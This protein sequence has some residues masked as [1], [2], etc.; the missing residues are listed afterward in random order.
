ME[1]D[2]SV[3]KEKANR[4][5]RRIWLIFAILLSANY[6]S[7]LANGLSTSTYYIIFL[8]LCWI[9]IISG[10]ILLRAKGFAT[11]AYKYN[12]V[13]GYGVFY[14]FVISTTES[15]IAFTYILPVTSLLVLYK[16]K[17]FMVTCGIVNSLIIAGSSVYRY[18]N[19]FNTA[20]DLKNYQLE[21]ACIILCYVCYVMSIKHLNESDGAMTDSIKA[22]LKRVVTTVEKVKQASNSIM[23]GVTVVR[24][25]ASENSHGAN[26]VVDS[27]DRLR[28]NNERLH[29]S[30]DSSSQMTTDINLQ[31]NNVVGMIDK[32]VALTAESGKHARV[33]SSD[34]DSLID[35][36]KTMASLSEEIG[37]ILRTFKDEFAM[38]KNETGTIENI[39]GQTNLLALNASIE[40]AR[41]GEA[42]KGFAVVADQIRS[43][44]TD[45]RA[46]SGT[47]KEALTR[48]D[49]TS[50]KM[51]DSIEQTL[52]LIQ[53][54]LDK[55]MLAA[56]NIAKI[57]EDA[58]ELD[59]NIRMI[60]TAIKDVESSNIHL[61]DNLTE[62]TG[63]VADMTESVTD[64]NEI[65]KRMLS[66]YDETASN[67]NSIEK[68][69]E[70]L[71]CELGIGGFMGVEDLL[72][73][74]KL[75]VE[76]G[77]DN[78][79]YGELISHDD[80]VMTIRLNNDGIIADNTEC[81]VQVTVGNV[82]YC[83]DKVRVKGI[84]A[85]RTYS[86]FIE[87]R[88]K[89]NNRRKYPRVDIDNSCTVTIK[90]TGRSIECKLDN[91]S[92]NG[93]A[94]ITRDACFMDH[95]SEEI[96]MEIHDFVLT[97]HNRLEGRVIRCSDDEGSYI[98]GCQ[99]PEDDFFIRDYVSERLK[100]EK[101]QR[102]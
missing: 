56:G 32:M 69:V 100:K 84:G 80:D 11:E 27:M 64:S 92:A 63:I 28:E 45:T 40:A 17:K 60:D 15:P 78:K 51:T 79:Y 38:V 50:V 24:E 102:K 85:A 66:K 6:G 20:S 39:S 1:Y 43:L 3:F 55:V 81:K 44:S 75:M 42:G 10:E 25:L 70:S 83:W 35:T 2:E 48:L 82:L 68:V 86:V 76:V 8:A 21:L 101:N 33:S 98:V 18:M 77:T 19:G 65:S 72:P 7:D 62:V 36:T 23:D 31:V 49:D 57:S 47:I 91:I 94:F 16:N 59:N 46:S 4:R 95:K 67:I 87:S 73:G 99:M 90:D 58:G 13:I 61:V 96:S 93:F 5:A 52:Q 34:L 30:T 37:N 89:I 88:P 41:A 12:L 97:R 22:D 53:L 29:K 9:P 71:M 14:T 54:T 74:M 26:I